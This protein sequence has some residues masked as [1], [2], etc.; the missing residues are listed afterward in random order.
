MSV[1]VGIA[2]ESGAYDGLGICR[3]II[4]VVVIV[5]V[6]VVV[7]GINGPGRNLAHRR[8][9]LDA[10]NV[11]F[12]PWNGSGGL[13]ASFWR[14]ELA[15][16]MALAMFAASSV[17]EFW[18]LVPLALDLTLGFLMLDLLLLPVDLLALF[19]PVS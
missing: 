17:S 1:Q 10:L 18:L 12:A 15:R 8:R 2:K 3:F 11:W 7:V 6:V 19:E 16:A 5:V 4:I 14:S 13:L 9:K